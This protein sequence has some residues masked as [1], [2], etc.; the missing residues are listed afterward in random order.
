MKT[1]SLLLLTMLFLFSCQEDRLDIDLLVKVPPEELIVS[2][3]FDS[4]APLAGMV[5]M[6]TT[7]PAMASL[8]IKGPEP[9]HISSSGITREHEIPLVGLYPDENNQ[10]IY[11]VVDPSLKKFAVDSFTIAAPGL[12]AFMPE[13]HVD[14]LEETQMEPGW[15]ILELSVGG[16][17]TYQ[18]VP[19]AFDRSGTIRWYTDLGWTGNWT[20]P[21]EPVQ[22]GRFGFGINNLLYTYDK[23]GRVAN[24]WQLTGYSQ[25]HDLFEKPDGNWIVP[26][27]KHGLNTSLDFIVEID[28]QSGEIVREWDLREVLDIDRFELIRYPRDWLHVNSVWLD[29]RDQGLVISAKHQ[30]IFK[31]SQDNE[32]QWILAPHKGWG[33]AGPD[34]NGVETSGYLLTA[35]DA[36]GQPYSQNVQQGME[37]HP[38]FDWSW[39]QHATMILSDGNLLVFDNGLHRY[40]NLNGPKFS[41]AVIYHIDE[42]QRTVRQVWQYGQARGESFFSSIISD[43]DYL[44]QTGNVLL[45]SGIIRESDPQAKVVEVSYP[46]KEV[47]FEATVLLRNLFSHSNSWGETDIVY[48]GERVDFVN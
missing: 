1:N 12:P 2:V 33:K 23:L 35:V 45:I 3:E 21:F 26:V 37:G 27:T 36:Q 42:E 34:G 28:R 19:L 25:H 5:R 8:E 20:A 13:I 18:T 15:T 30:G 38:D 11:K 4:T 39:G 31:V 24:R 22:N 14:H 17:S 41:R 48:R 7:I 47:V 6:E 40:F 32:L 10:V 43:V 44:P 46:D 16:Q 29:E 9:A